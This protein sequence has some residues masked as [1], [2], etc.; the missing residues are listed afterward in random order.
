MK[1]IIAFVLIFTSFLTETFSQKNPS[2]FI[3]TF[4]NPPVLKRHAEQVKRD[5]F[6]LHNYY[7]IG[8]YTDLEAD[9]SALNIAQ[10]S[11]LK[12]LFRANGSEDSENVISVLQNQHENYWKTITEHPA[13]AGFFLEDEPLGNDLKK[14]KE[15]YELYKSIDSNSDHIALINF[16]PIYTSKDNLGC[17]PTSLSTND[18]YEQYINEYTNS[19]DFDILCYDFY[20]FDSYRLNGHH[21]ADYFINLEILRTKAKEKEIPLIGMIQATQFEPEWK[22]PSFEELSWQTYTLMSYGAKGI[23]WFVYDMSDSD[24]G[25]YNVHYID[26]NIPGDTYS[27]TRMPVANKVAKVNQYIKDLGQELINLE[28]THVYHTGVPQEFTTPLPY[29]CPITVTGGDFVVGLFMDESSSE[30]YFMVTNKDFNNSQVANIQL[31]IGHGSLYRFNI[32]VSDN[33]FPETNDWEVEANWEVVPA[34]NEGYSEILAAG[35]GTLFKFCTENSLDESESIC[36]SY[37]TNSNSASNP[38]IGKTVTSCSGTIVSN[39]GNVVVIAADEIIIDSNFEVSIGGQFYAHTQ[40]ILN[41]IPLCSNMSLKKASENK[42]ALM[43]TKIKGNSTEFIEDL[44]I[45]YPNPSKGTVQIKSNLTEK[46]NVNI[47][48]FNSVGLLVNS[49]NLN[50]VEN[51]TNTIDLLDIEEGMY[52]ISIKTDKTIINKS[53]IIE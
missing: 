23:V 6:N 2:E 35:S 43:N 40:S 20:R 34:Q 19:I 42:S 53:L 37:S 36:G 46:S 39:G 5:G 4:W 29:N 47:K 14:W 11:G 51:E 3:I 8:E 7:K 15:A 18:C 16:Y 26:E 50:N 28:S 17:N 30:N 32:S 48:V 10:N 13:Y 9:L 27:H 1:K 25:C 12:V 24:L 41:N 21:G 38:I 44:F 45:L 33:Q 31:N 52:I 22:E 49:I